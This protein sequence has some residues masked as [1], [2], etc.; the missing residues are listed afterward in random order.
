[1]GI[2]PKYEQHQV[3][4][5]QQISNWQD[6]DKWSE[7]VRQLDGAPYPKQYF[8]TLTYNQRDRE[9]DC[10]FDAA[11]NHVIQFGRYI[12]RQVKGHVELFSVY[13]DSH[14]H[15]TKHTNDGS[16][17]EIHEHIHMII[18]GD[19]EIPMWLIQQSW[20]MRPSQRTIEYKRRSGHYN[21]TEYVSRGFIYAEPFQNE[22]KSNCYAYMYGGHSVAHGIITPTFCGV[23]KHRNNCQ[24]RRE[25]TNRRTL[26]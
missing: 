21:P 20:Q 9:V 22:K 12:S 15:K 17:K 3:E 4:R 13:G 7:V 1:M 24:Q 26:V 10:S 5:F 14:I 19:V 25:S 6:W 2:A 8:A 18:T 16:P 23:R 11:R